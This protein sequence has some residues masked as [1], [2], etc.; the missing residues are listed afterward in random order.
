MLRTD[1]AEVQE[2]GEAMAEV[3]YR[4]VRLASLHRR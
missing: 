1:L 3:R 2:K 4:G